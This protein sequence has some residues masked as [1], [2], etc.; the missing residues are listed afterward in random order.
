MI[1]RAMIALLTLYQKLIS[2][3][4]HQILGVQKLCRYN[5]SCSEYAKQSIEEYGILHGGVRAI[6]RLLTCQPFGHVT[7]K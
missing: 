4:V 6:K 2:P 3:L 7:T 5:V 1:K